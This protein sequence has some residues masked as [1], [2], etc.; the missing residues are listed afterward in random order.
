MKPYSTARE[1]SATPDEL[2]LVREFSFG[3]DCGG[4]RIIHGENARVLAHLGASLKGAVRCIY[5][6]PPYNNQERYFH[7]SDALSHDDWM[8]GIVERLELM[9]PLLTE[10]GSIWISIDDREVHYL[11]VAADR[12]FGR[13]NFVST[14][15]WQQRTTRENRK[16]F[17]NN[18]EYL[19]VY[20]RDVK[21]FRLSR[22]RLPAT[23]E[24]LGRYKNPDGDPRGSWQSVSANVQGGHGTDS[25]FYVLVAP[26]GRRH[27]P[28]KG[29]CW[30]YTKDRMDR[31][32]RA[33]N[34]WFGRDGNGAPRLKR[35]LA[36]SPG[37]TPETLWFATDVGTNDSAKKHL[38]SLFAD[39]PVFD[40]PKPEE[41][42]ARVLH[43]ATRPGDMVLDAYLGSG[44]TAAVAHKMGRRYIGIEEGGH[45]VTHCATR[46]RAVVEGEGGG[47]SAA[48]GWSGGGGF[49]FYRVGDTP[50]LVAIGAPAPRST[51]TRRR[52][53]RPR[54][55]RS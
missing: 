40:T 52:G 17:S 8:G 15:I 37:L 7:Y 3:E 18:H 32:I 10:D 29:R 27:A 39:A 45:A 35:F 36:E 47:V 26:N 5:I 21:R 49:E 16:V 1:L 44:T 30:V 13:E 51:V 55:S 19:L 12:I 46:L 54:R 20:A 53:R 6:D 34:V 9:A 11:K 28:P 25:Q 4:N 48:V 14:V 22:N 41:L 33:N 23:P 24:V 2:R 31:E 42:I 50:P 43:I 38:L